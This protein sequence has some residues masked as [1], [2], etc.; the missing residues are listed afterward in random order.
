MFAA[1]YDALAL[2]VLRPGQLFAHP[3]PSGSSAAIL[4]NAQFE[5]T[6]FSM[7]PAFSVPHH[8]LLGAL[9]LCVPQNIDRLDSEWCI[10]WLELDETIRRK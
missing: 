2:P 5:V 9:L 10:T 8:A 1:V 7:W 4:A 3:I 6:V